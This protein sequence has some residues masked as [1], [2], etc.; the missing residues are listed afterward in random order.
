MPVTKK[1]KN[2]TT[3]DGFNGRLSKIIKSLEFNDKKSNFK[4][5]TN[6]KANKLKYH[7]HERC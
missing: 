3:T 6:H 2:N 7:Y 5:L 1:E 4:Q